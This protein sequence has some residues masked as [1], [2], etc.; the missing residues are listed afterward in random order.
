MQQDRDWIC[1][2]GKLDHSLYYKDDLH[3]VE[4]GYDKLAYTI[5]KILKKI[6]M[7]VERNDEEFAIGQL[8]YLGN[9][10]N[11]TDGKQQMHIRPSPPTHLLPYDVDFPPLPLPLPRVSPSN[12]FPYVSKPMYCP[13]VVSPPVCKMSIILFIVLFL[14]MFMLINLLILCL[15]C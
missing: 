15:S 10:W 13:S 9:G 7:K 14:V 5:T 4:K 6:E 8:E 1:E 2:D 3:L 12:L 11:E